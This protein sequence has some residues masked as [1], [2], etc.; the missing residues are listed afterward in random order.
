VC[1]IG[2]GVSDCLVDWHDIVIV[3]IG[4][5]RQCRARLSH[6]SVAVAHDVVVVAASNAVR[7]AFGVAN[8][9]AVCAVISVVVCVD[10]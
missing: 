10:I 5:S 7:V 2:A 3:V 9:A 6:T 1:G 8:G 4:V